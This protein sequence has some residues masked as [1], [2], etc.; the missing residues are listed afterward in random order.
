[1]SGSELGEFLEF[2]SFVILVVKL[3]DL[4]LDITRLFREGVFREFIFRI[5]F[6]V[7]SW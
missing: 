1:M 2:V 5:E 6:R 7:K 4:F 3:E